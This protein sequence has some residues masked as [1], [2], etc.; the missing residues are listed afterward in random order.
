MKMMMMKV[1][2]ILKTIKSIFKTAKQ[3]EDQIEMV[4]KTM[5]F[6]PVWVY[7]ECFRFGLEDKSVKF[8]IKLH[9]PANQLNDENIIATAK[10]FIGLKYGVGEE[11]TT[12]KKWNFK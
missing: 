7:G 12:I 4:S 6:K 3:F 1:M 10:K 11:L 8:R 9:F 2:V 5:N